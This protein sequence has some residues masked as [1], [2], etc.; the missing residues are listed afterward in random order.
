VL[1]HRCYC[2]LPCPGCKQS[3][4]SFLHVLSCCDT[5]AMDHRSSAL[6]HLLSSLK[7]IDTPTKIIAALEHGFQ[8]WITPPTSIH[9]PSAGQLGSSAALLRSAFHTQF[10][11]IG[12]LHL[13]LGCLSRYWQAAYKILTPGSTNLSSQL[14]LSSVSSLIWQYTYSLWKY[15]NK[16]VHEETIT[17]QTTHLWNRLCDTATN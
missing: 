16:I 14:W 10:Y 1:L 7:Q 5:L 6:S 2:C 3:K 13:Q 12:W 4:E 8:H 17:G 11:D 9:A 15:Q